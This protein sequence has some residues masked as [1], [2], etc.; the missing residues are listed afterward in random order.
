MRLHRQ[1]KQSAF[2]LLEIMLV[3]GIIVIILGVAVSKLGNTTGVAK[4]MR[5]RADIQAISTQLKLYESVNGFVPTTEQGLQALVTPPESDP[6]PTRWYQLFKELPQDPWS[7]NYVYLSPGRKN[8]SGFDLYSAGQ[9]RKA[10][11]ADDNWGN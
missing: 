6:K 10:E 7:N 2:T 3:V 4:D 9:D 11:T 8:P 5:V 1:N